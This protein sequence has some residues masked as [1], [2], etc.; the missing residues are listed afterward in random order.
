MSGV[1]GNR[2]FP[3]DKYS[4]N[5]IRNFLI[6]VAEN[7]RCFYEELRIVGD[8]HINHREA[9]DKINESIR[10]EQLYGYTIGAIYLDENNKKH[11]LVETS[12]S[13]KR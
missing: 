13:E 1:I 7:E 11:L 3:L 12:W 8:T 9:Q 10:L 2:V 4:I 5:D 6:G